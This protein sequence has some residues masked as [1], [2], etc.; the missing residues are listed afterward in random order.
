ML[1]E[2]AGQ[3]GANMILGNLELQEFYADFLPAYAPA[4]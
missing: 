3:I 4:Q 1:T 2:V